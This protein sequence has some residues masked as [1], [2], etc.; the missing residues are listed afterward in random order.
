MKALWVDG[1]TDGRM[2]KKS[3]NT[4]VIFHA[5]S[6]HFQFSKLHRNIIK[7]NNLKM[8]KK[9]VSKYRTLLKSVYVCLFFFILLNR[10]HV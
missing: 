5:F 8:K 6:V 10:D 7:S 3:L 1:W 2:D 4:L 9:K